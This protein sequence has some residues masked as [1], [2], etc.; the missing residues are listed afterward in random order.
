MMYV[1]EVL[2][3]SSKEY[4]LSRLDDAQFLQRTE[5]LASVFRL[6]E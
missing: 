2:R 6:L 4:F 5:I 1:S 3:M